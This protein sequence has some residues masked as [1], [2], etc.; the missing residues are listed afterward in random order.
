MIAAMTNAMDYRGPD[1]INHWN[2]GQTALGYCAMHTTAE[3]RADDQ[4]LASQDGNIRVML[5]G[6]IAN[7]HALLGE[8]HERGAILTTGSEAE[9]VLRAY[10][11]WGEDFPRHID[12]EY[13]IIIWDGRDGRALCARDHI[14]LR[15][16]H[17]YRDDT[18]L[19]VA[20]EIA[21]V[22]AA[23]PFAPDIDRQILAE[24]MGSE[25]LTRDR[26]AWQGILRLLPAHSMSYERGQLETNEYWQIPTEV[27]IKYPR[28]EDYVTH[29]LSILTEC[30]KMAARTDGPLACEV[31]GGLDS[32]AIFSLAHKL[33][34]KGQLPAPAL[35]GYTLA[36]PAGSAA[37]EIAYVRE[38]EDKVGVEIAPVDMF[39]PPL[40]WYAQQVAQDRDL[41]TYANTS[42]L[43]NLGRLLASDGCRVALNGQGGDQLLNGRPIYYYE[44]LAYGE[45]GTFLSALR[46]DAAAFGFRRALSMAARS[47]LGP[48][49]PRWLDW[50][51]AIFRGPTGSSISKDRQELYWI[52][53]E[54]RANL[55]ERREKYLQNMVDRRR[56][57]KAQS[58]QHPFALRFF[59]TF[60]RQCAR[61]GYEP[62]SPMLARPYIEFLAS[63]P[64]RQK[65]RGGL[66]K[67]LHRQAMVGIL[68]EAIRT[69]TSKAEF[70]V[71][72]D[73]LS[74][75]LCEYLRGPV[76]Q[77][78]FDLVDQAGI[79]RLADTFCG[80]PIDSW[81]NWE[82]MGTHSAHVFAKNAVIADIGG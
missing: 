20:T 44:A 53:P 67:L 1:G 31:S 63:I 71:V 23:L 75:D 39:T 66:G 77:N 60:S 28:D 15:P 37:D 38:L 27:S 3:A 82:V 78:D 10:E 81:V 4:P 2:S 6:Y 47:V 29:Y 58:M 43:I 68:P 21:A 22:L 50:I 80:A 76:Y 33:A 9:L 8:L 55:I 49:I 74:K 32:G 57:K 51:R 45:P 14:G 7:Y 69:R 46:E 48:F 41:A 36:T 79:Q 72:Y 56:P 26:T 61:L 19:I 13:A 40:D 24:V 54:L 17:Y 30:I 64:E 42:M 34:D 5:D 11:A 62:R 25:W 12:G 16:L 59:D 73:L 70:S 52:A 65:L 18:Q 35:R